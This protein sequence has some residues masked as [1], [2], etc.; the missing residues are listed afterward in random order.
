MLV[1]SISGSAFHA[2]AFMPVTVGDTFPPPAVLS[3]RTGSGFGLAI[4][5]GLTGGNCGIVVIE[6]G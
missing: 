2:V 3:V 4:I 5:C 6:N 1:A